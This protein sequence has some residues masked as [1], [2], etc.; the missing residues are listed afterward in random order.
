MTNLITALELRAEAQKVGKTQL[1][2][3]YDADDNLLYIGISLSTMVRLSQHRSDSA[4]SERIV[5]VM[6][7]HFATREEALAA[8]DAAI[9]AE[10]PL[11]NVMGK[12]KT[13][14]FYP[15]VTMT[16]RNPSSLRETFAKMGLKPR[17]AP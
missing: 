13:K 12:G 15:T 8:E 11:F 5:R 7:E 6:I 4:W 14:K 2:R 17:K 10:K 3:H 9:K 1:Y 16:A